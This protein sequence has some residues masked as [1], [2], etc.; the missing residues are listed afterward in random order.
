M[1]PYRVP[2]PRSQRR[3]GLTSRQ[4]TNDG[5]A[6]A[7]EPDGGG[8]GSNAE[9][10]GDEPPRPASA[11]REVRSPGEPRNDGLYGGKPSPSEPVAGGDDHGAGPAANAGQNDGV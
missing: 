4:S 11:G 7:G 10:D 8:L 9:G 1:V 5:D 6:D 2:H 3:D